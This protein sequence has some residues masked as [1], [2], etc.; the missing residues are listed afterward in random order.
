MNAPINITRTQTALIAAD[1]VSYS[2]NLNQLFCGAYTFL[3]N[4]V[5]T[6]PPSLSDTTFITY[7]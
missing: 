5:S 1:Y 3:T 2:K 7:V 4:I 6:I